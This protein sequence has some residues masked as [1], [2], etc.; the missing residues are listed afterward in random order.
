MPFGGGYS[1]YSFIGWRRIQVR[2]KLKP[3]H[4]HSSCDAMEI[5]L[6][7]MKQIHVINTYWLWFVLPV[8]PYL[9]VRWQQRN[10]TN[11]NN[12]NAHGKQTHIDSGVRAKKQIK[13]ISANKTYVKYNNNDIY[14]ICG[15]NYLFDSLNVPSVAD[16]LWCHHSFVY[17]HFAFSCGVYSVRSLFGSPKKVMLLLAWGVA[18]VMWKF[19]GIQFQSHQNACE[20]VTA[21]HSNSKHHDWALSSWE[22]VRAFHH[23][24]II[25]HH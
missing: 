19:A 5:R 6:E 11:A 2:D 4:T 10:C 12:V 13:G 7:V 23:L 21:I 24:A 25:V 16:A 15:E 20:F 3:T 1:K 8:E 22:M 18:H 14:L 9:N 17:Y